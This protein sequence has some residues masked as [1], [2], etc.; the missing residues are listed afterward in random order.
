MTQETLVLD[1]RL[2]GYPLAA[3][4]CDPEQIATLGWNLYQDDLPYPIAVLD[5]QALS[6]NLQWMQAFAQARDIVIAPHGKTTLS[7][8]IFRRQLDAGAWGLTFATVWQAGVGVRAGAQ[9]VMIANQVV[10]DA[11]LDG[12]VA[13]LNTNPGLR[14][15]FL[16]DSAEQVARIEDWARRRQHRTPLDCLLEIGIAGQRTGCRTA[17]QAMT[18]ARRIH[19]SLA[20]RLGG[21]ECYEGGLA[22]GDA[23]ADQKAVTAFLDG[24]R[25]I[26]QDCDRVGLFQD[27]TIIL[28]A[29]GSAVFDVVAPALRAS[30]SRPLLGVLRSGCYIAHDHD[31]YAGFM[32]NIQSRSGLDDGL[33]P[34]LTVWALVQSVPEPGLALLSVGKR[35]VSFDLSL[36][37]PVGL[38]PHGALAN[39][40]VPTGWS[41]TGLND[42]HAYLRFDPSGAV[43]PAVGDR[44]IL[45]ISHPCTTF[46]K[47]AWMPL[48]DAR[49]HVVG[50]ITT[51]F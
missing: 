44:V 11:D 10:A 42:H 32:R 24:V 13:L 30:V 3:A 35:D 43:I 2:K 37:Q 17:E 31:F 23:Q 34:A 12:V 16:V 41:I 25:E 1:G 19:A 51:A 28:T 46:D 15:W 21:I 49:G 38:A 26:T 4:P 47:W 48:A 20:L 14:L 45:G 5:E 6:H 40:P 50:A 29:G 27:E 33:R 39:Q 9:R 7:P 22:H 18:L 8:Q 36:P